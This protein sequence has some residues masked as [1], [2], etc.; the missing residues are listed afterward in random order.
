MD[1]QQMRY[2][3]AVAEERSFT[4]AAERCHVVQSALSHQ[5][6]GLER[7]LGVVLFA[8]TSRRVE[9]TAAGEAFL[10]A[11]RV[12]LDAA[13]RAVS[14][15]A[16]AAGEIRGTLTIGVIPTVTA[17]DI[18]AALGAFHR[19]HPAVRIRLRGGGSDEFIA[20]IADGSMDVA[21]LGLPDTMTPKNVNTRVL[22]RERLAAVVSADHALAARRRL[23]LEDLVDEAFVDFPEGTPGRAPS[24]L[25]FRAAGLHR[26]VAFEAMSTDLML[27]LVKNN[28]VI[29]LLSPAVIPD[30]DELRTIPVTSGPTRVEYLAW[31][32]FNVSPVAQAFLEGL[33]ATE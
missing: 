18:P 32:G 6:K 1:L 10:A 33:A 11:A 7:E 23:R 8:R 13:E 29:A 20:A 15:A 30:S 12:S 3:V 25:A 5:I 2:A 31:S 9:V 28:L 16:A 14:D 19:K 22:A 27:S 4:R 17:I 21:V 26:E 24:D